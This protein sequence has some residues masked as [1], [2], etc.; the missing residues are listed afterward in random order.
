MVMI[1]SVTETDLSTDE[2]IMNYTDKI[3]NSLKYIFECLK[4]MILSIGLGDLFLE[5]LEELKE[6][7]F[8]KFYDCK[9]DI[10]KLKSF[11]QINITDMDE[12]FV[13][14]VRESCVGYS[15]SFPPVDKVNSVN[16][17]LHVTHSYVINNQMILQSFNVVDTK[18][19]DDYANINLYGSNSELAK[20]IFVNFPI[21]ID[22]GD[23]DIVSVT[24]NKV[25][26]MIRDKGHALTMEID[27]VGDEVE[28]H[29]FIPKLCNIGMINMLPGV[30]KV[31]EDAPTHSGTNGVFYSKLDNF[32]EK[33][34]EFVEMVPTDSDMDME[35]FSNIR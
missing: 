15:F 14:L 22:C 21:D 17:M 31:K 10:D 16:E 2:G 18:P 6:N 26:M 30:R 19:I 7:T 1:G 11:Y 20:N 29:Y 34:Y 32:V 5:K 24:D 8:N 25:I 28:C 13:D 3:D 12:K 27:K 9:F 4:R 33:L 23:V 35:R